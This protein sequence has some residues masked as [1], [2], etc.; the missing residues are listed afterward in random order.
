MG[1]DVSRSSVNSVVRL[2]PLVSATKR[3]VH[4]GA[5]ALELCYL[6]DGR[7]DAFVDIRGK[8]RITD[9]AAAFLI[10]KEAG[11]ILTD[12]AGGPLRPAFDLESRFGFIGSANLGLHKE[13]LRLVRT[14][15]GKK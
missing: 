3:Q 4:F 9:F 7:I 10:A 5:N 8:I 13:I 12:E 14:S 15:G 1:I 11:A 2:A 6:A